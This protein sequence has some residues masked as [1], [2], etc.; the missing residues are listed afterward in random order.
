MVIEALDKERETKWAIKK[1]N[2]EKVRLLII[3]L[4][5]QFYC[6]VG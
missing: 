3:I 4:R 5:V 6:K 1:V 2:K